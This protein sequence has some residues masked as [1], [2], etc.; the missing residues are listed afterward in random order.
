MTPIAPIMLSSIRPEGSASADAFGVD[1]TPCMR[2]L[3]H[4]E[5]EDQQV[6]G[7]FTTDFY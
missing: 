7:R 1:I 4:G 6:Y 5:A 2:L 3:G